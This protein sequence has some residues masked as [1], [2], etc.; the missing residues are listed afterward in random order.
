MRRTTSLFFLFVFVVGVLFGALVVSYMMSITSKI[1]NTDTLRIENLAGY[2]QSVKIITEGTEHIIKI[3][4]KETI[5]IKANFKENLQVYLLSLDYEL[6]DK[7]EFK[8][9]EVDF[10]TK[11]I[12]RTNGEEKH[13]K[14]DFTKKK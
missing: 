8:L 7:T 4:K 12:N 14:V 3:G 1:E 13:I 5:Q 6:D 2:T 10:I 11:R 9:L